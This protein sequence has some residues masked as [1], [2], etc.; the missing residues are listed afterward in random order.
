MKKR[1]AYSPGRLV[2]ILTFGVFG[3]I[4]TEMGVVGII[5]QIAETF[6]VTVPQAGWTVG[7]F[8]L[9]VAVSAPVMP[10]LFSG[11]DR[12]TVMLLAL[13]LF[14][15]G[16]IVSALT[17]SFAVLLAARALP[18]FLHP[19]Y[20]SMAFSTAAASVRSEEAPKAVSKVFIGVSAGMVLGV[21]V[22]S[23]IAGH[24]SFSA[25]MAFFA[26][27]NAATLAA[28]LLCV[29]RLP[30]ARR[31]SYGAQLGVLKKAVMR[32]SLIAFTLINGA[33][34][35]FFSYMSDFLNRVT[36]VSSDTASALLLVYGGANIAG[37]LLAGRLLAAMHAAA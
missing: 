8:A 28:T 32:R 30:V 36:E 22:T 24:A 9:V 16:N 17:D 27:V 14:T 6:G 20:M 19:A 37:N 12:R 34:F 26:A 4:N 13:G 21:P 31:I 23:L 7:V 35:G 15:A 10:L 18:A 1:L 11:T 33:M 29:P 5:P 2:A 3:I 25:A